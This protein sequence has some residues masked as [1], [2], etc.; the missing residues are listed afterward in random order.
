MFDKDDEGVLKAQ[1][2]GETDPSAIQEQFEKTQ[3]STERANVGRLADSTRIADEIF[4]KY[5]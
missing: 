1:K 4:A 5:Q 2:N 3:A